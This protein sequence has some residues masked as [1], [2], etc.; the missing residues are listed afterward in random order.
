MAIKTGRSD[1]AAQPSIDTAKC[2][3]CGLCAA[4]CP[5]FT[6]KQ[7]EGGIAIDEQTEFGCIGCGQCMAICPVQAV[8]VTG[9]ELSPE[10][11]VELPPRDARANPEQLAGL[12]QARRSIRHFSD[13]DVEPEVL[14]RVL[15]MAST[16]PMGIPPSDVEI[17]V[18][19]GR[20]RV[21]AFASDMNK[22]FHGTVKFF[23]PLRLTLMRPVLGKT[24]VEMFKCFILPL[25]REIIRERERG[26]DVLLYNAPLAMLFHSSPFSDPV[27]AN[28]AATYAM[29]AAES[30]GLG[31]CMI[32]SVSPFLMRDKKL[33][34]KYGIKR[35][36]K[37]GIMVVMGYPRYQ[38]SNALR[39]TFA[40]VNLYQG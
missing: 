25:C 10:D 40:N 22:L 6:L 33:M 9:R 12:L 7:A 26:R 2:T 3:A 1:Q 24:N 8:K 34:D 15:Q 5:S 20:R 17:L 27:D 28:I 21:Q 16:A 11:V 13:S 23:T 18:L 35:G 31:T 32:G 38:F 4:I 37:L 14:G 39:R 30:L 29:L 19:S 36:N